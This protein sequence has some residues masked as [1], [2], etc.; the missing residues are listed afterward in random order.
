M[1]VRCVCS[2]HCIREQDLLQQLIPVII[3]TTTILHLLP[4]AWGLYHHCGVSFLGGLIPAAFAFLRPPV[5]PAG[6]P[7]RD[8]LRHT[9]PV[10]IWIQLLIP[11]GQ[12]LQHILRHRLHRTVLSIKRDFLN[13]IPRR[14]WTLLLHMAGSKANC[15][16]TE[17]EINVHLRNWP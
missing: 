8:M 4:V 9:A 15:S 1:P 10:P 5:R 13:M 16:A 6:V 12:H 3:P 2:T 7:C 11:R 14:E 17:K